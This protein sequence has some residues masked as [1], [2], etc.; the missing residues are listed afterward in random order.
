MLYINND[1]LDP[2]Y[3]MALEEYILKNTDSGE[4]CLMLWRNKP[5]VIVGRFQNTIAE[6]N[7]EY[8][9][10]NNIAVVRRLSGG[11]S[12][13]HD[14]GNINFTFIE[15]RTDNS[16]GFDRYT[17]RVV[18]ALGQ[19][20]VR[21]EVSGRNDITI[22]GMKFSGN[23]QYHYRDRVLHHGTILYSADLADIGQILRVKADKIESKGIKSVRSRVTNIQKYLPQQLSVAEF[24]TRFKELLVAG[25]KVREHFLSAEDRAAVH[26]LK[27][28]KYLTWE[29]NYGN[30]PAF[31]LIKHGRFQCGGIEIGLAVERG[32][33]RSCKIYG[34]FFSGGD[35]DLAVFEDKLTGVKYEEQT[36][37]SVI[38]QAELEQYFGPLK[39]EELMRLLFG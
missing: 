7:V 15:K 29:W 17:A 2:Y 14:P 38:E 16:A 10:R 35:S 11:G 39:K 4:R 21:A 34:D 28:D 1:S 13:Y 25:D 24:M 19:M 23:A 30:S 22:D 6:V 5:A 37:D 26:R 9:K 27:D 32:L 36:L 3:N 8:V 33:I 18:R 20:G 31:N 12:V